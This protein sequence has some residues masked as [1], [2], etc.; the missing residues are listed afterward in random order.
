MGK[1]PVQKLISAT[2]R[3]HQLTCVHSD[4]RDSLRTSV[5]TLS[6]SALRLEEHRPDLP[7]IGLVLA[8]D[9]GGV[10]EER[11]AGNLGHTIQI[12]RVEGGS[13]DMRALGHQ[14]GD[15]VLDGPLLVEFGDGLLGVVLV[16]ELR[17]V[18]RTADDVAD[19]LARLPVGDRK[20]TRLNSSHVAI[21]Y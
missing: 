9:S 17:A 13:P 2:T 4:R 10:T 1:T 14:L 15:L 7:E 20:S 19:A 21:S 12:H 11:R 18:S 5:R 16:P 8:A 6:A 3:R